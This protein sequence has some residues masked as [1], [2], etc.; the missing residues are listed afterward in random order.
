M[1]TI[2]NYLVIPLLIN[3][4][5]VVKYDSPIPVTLYGCAMHYFIIYILEP[6]FCNKH[7]EFPKF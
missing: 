2:I 6:L 7:T 3:A 5:F 4:K 1:L